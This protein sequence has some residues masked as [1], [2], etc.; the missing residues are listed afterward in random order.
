MENWHRI[1]RVGLMNASGT[2]FQ[3]HG[4]AYGKGVYLSPHASV[5]FGYSGMGHGGPR[6]VQ[7]P[8]KMVSS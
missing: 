1:M 5:S 4:A 8:D 2:R 7:R 3:M 6:A